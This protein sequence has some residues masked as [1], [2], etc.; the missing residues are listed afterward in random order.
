MAQEKFKPS[1]LTIAALNKSLLLSAIYFLL[2]IAGLK[3]AIAPGYATAVFPAAGLAF[4]AILYEGSRLLPGVW[5][6]SV[7][8][9]L[10]VAA[11]HSGLSSESLLTA[12]IIAA[13]STL[14]AWVA[15]SLV[16]HRLKDSWRNLDNDRDI[17]LLLFFA[18]PLACLV[19]AT[20][21]NTVL[22]LFHVISSSELFFNWW[23][24]WIGDTIGVLL[25]APLTLMV[26][27]RKNPLWKSRFKSVA[28]PSLIVT[29][30]IIAAFV[31]VSNIEALRL[32]QHIAERGLSLSN[33]LQSTLLSYGEIL[34]SVDNLI[35]TYPNLGLSEFE[36]FSRQSF[37][38]HP[39]LQALSWNLVLKGEAREKLETDLGKELHINGLKITQRDSSGKLI[40]ADYRDEYVVVRYITP[41]DKNRDA[42]AYDIAS[43]TVRYDAIKAAART[44]KPSATAPIR[45]VQ[46]HSPGKGVLLLHPVYLDQRAAHHPN[47]SPY[48]F[49]VG[50][51][52]VEDMLKQLFAKGLPKD[53]A[54]TIED[55]GTSAGNGLLYRS[56]QVSHP[57]LSMFA[58]ED[59]VPF[60][61]R[62]WLISLSPTPEYMA[63]NRSLQAWMVLAGGLILAS[64]LQA[65]LLAITGRTSVIRRRVQEQTKTLQRES[66]KNRA[67]LWN[68]SDG[69]H[70]L[71]FD[72]N[73][74]EASDSFCT[75]LG[76]RRDEVI[77]MNVAEWD[78]GFPDAEELLAA[79]RQQLESPVRVQF[80]TR[81]RR[82]DG[83]IFDVEISGFPLE[84]DGQHVLFN[85]SRDITVRKQL[86]ESLRVNEQKLRGLYELSPIGIALT[87]MDGKFV[88]FNQSFQKI[89]GYSSD[90]LMNLDYWQLTPR[91]YEASEALQLES[92]AN[93]GRYGP[94]E[95]EYIHKDGSLI[96]LRLNGILVT[97]ADGKDYIWSM[98]ENIAD[99]KKAEQSL[100]RE[101]EKSLALLRNASDGIH[102]LD[103]DGNIIEASDSFCTMLGYRRDEIIGMNVS[104]WDAMFTSSE[105]PQKLRQP[106]VE[107]SR[108]QFETRH[109]RK[110]GSV[111]DVEISGFPLEQEGTP[112]LFFSS[113]DITERKQAE[114]ELRIAA[115]A[116][117]SQE[118]MMVTDNNGAILRVNHAFTVVTGY[119]TKEV[120]GKNPRLLNSGRHDT[121]FF[122]KMWTSI[123]DAGSWKGEIWNRRKN[124]EVYP[125]HLTITAVTDAN[126]HIT[127][128]VATLIDITLSKAAAEKIEQLA[129]YD[130][131]T[132]LANRRLLL[133]R[134]Q[135]ALASSA[136][137]RLEGALLFLDLDN[138]KALNDTL[139]HDIGDLLLQQVAERLKACVREGDTVARLG[140]DEFV[141]ILE[142]LSKQ[143]IEAALPAEIVA[144]KIL[145]ALNEVYRLGK[146]EYRNTPSIGVTLFNEHKHPHK[147][148]E[149]LRQ[150]DIAMYQAKKASRNTLR[151]FDPMMQT[152]INNRVALEKALHEAI[153]KQQ[154]Q[155]HYQIQVHSSGLALGAE[156]LIR[157]QHPD[158]S[159]VPPTQFIPIAEEMGLILP[160]GQWVLETACAQIS[161]WQQDALTR[162]LVL[163][164]NVSVKQFHQANFIERVQHAVQRHA[165]NPALLKLEL[166]ESM[167]LESIDDTIITMNALKEVGI[168]ISLD[169]FGTGY[170]SLQYL[171]RLP[172]NQLK[173]D[174]SFVR[175][176]AVDANDRAIVRTII[177]MAQSLELSIIAEG[178]ETE[179]QREILIGN[180]CMNYQ[181][182]LFG[183]PVPIEQFEI[184]LKRG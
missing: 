145:A 11:N 173:I 6:G 9:N 156:A 140:G 5:L 64:L 42:I 154:F 162:D 122:T 69:I 96:P 60:N 120:I 74:I 36:R 177:A 107:Q 123:H 184:L 164:I 15:A 34:A 98:L 56:D 141:V 31:Y 170:S 62:F 95:K 113:R 41:L 35:Q 89:S 80:E 22:I 73:V 149:L 138:F 102:I 54:L 166:T 137:S 159:L 157:W 174:R 59:E 146:H 28:I 52:H 58:W 130:P 44:G 26:L 23:N 50:V 158:G 179:E 181:G 127:N 152:N 77:G 117:E 125:E 82:K 38:H 29:A 90:E 13:G 84:M 16:R 182:Y 68:A 39:D 163:S 134:L 76:Y 105:L 14:Q 65:F 112:L 67:L 63:S 172:I 180:G 40:P 142:N 92:L 78:A 3:L 110:D 51:F 53:L 101:S 4:A 151:F 136:R 129:F 46:E 100:K 30:G 49:A 20:W 97:G 24:W 91:R 8:I 175:D 87:R 147:T 128:Y 83:S 99:W 93:T 150:A 10:W 126:G 183:K 143:G 45:L 86:N 81:H 25:F 155:L 1:K 88:E 57:Q 161:A 148:D 176:I 111:F 94:Y 18:G 108:I 116:F 37:E 32:K 19:S 114:T 119:S 121:A 33:Q 133:D 165:I 153:E 66:E 106:Y 131:L 47:I 70:I 75:M 104:Q 168:L 115:A 109:R 72:G 79:V 43:D 132:G 55:K 21:A 118:G 71:D 17:I 139:G 169:D 61:G 85:S 171:K 48:G 27:Q 167:L 2:G 103:F 12:A 124:G 7:G 144:N 160:I 178:V 135:Q